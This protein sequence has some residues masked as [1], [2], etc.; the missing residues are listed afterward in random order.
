MP[1]G[2]QKNHT[3]AM[4][5]IAST[6]DGNVKEI[7]KKLYEELVKKYPNLRWQD[8]LKQ[9]QIPSGVGGCQPDGCIFIMQNYFLCSF[10]AKKQQD[11]GNVIER[12]FKNHYIFNVIQEENQP[13]FK[14]SY[15]TFVIG[16]GAIEGGVMWKALHIAHRKGF[17]TY[18]AGDT[19][20]YLSVDSF[21]EKEIY[22]IMK[23]TITERIET[24]ISSGLMTREETETTP[25][26]KLL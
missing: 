2:L 23:N 22:D 25:L 9:T 26:S 8:K 5:K 4:D 10:E 13:D 15:V 16:E 6:L 14:M 12:W 24:L 17:N 19:S 1:R 11:A 7:A 20:A 3:G 21:T 18:H